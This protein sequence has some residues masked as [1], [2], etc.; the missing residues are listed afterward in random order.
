MDGL[1]SFGQRL[2]RFDSGALIRVRDGI[3]WAQLP[4]AVLVAAPSD[5][6]GPAHSVLPDGVYAAADLSPRDAAQWRVLLP[7]TAASALH[8]TPQAWMAAGP[9]ARVVETVP[10]Q[11]IQQLATAAAQTL[12]Q[13]AGRAGERAIRDA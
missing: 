13:L 12:K 6:A 10:A 8:T 3:A 4:W 1:T 2:S 9:G 7:P 5:F 11:A